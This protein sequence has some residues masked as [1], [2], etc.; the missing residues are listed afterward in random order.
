MSEIV[1]HKLAS[2]ILPLELSQLAPEWFAVFTTTRHEKRVVEHLTMKEVETFLPLYRSVRKWNNGCKVP[3]NLPLFPNYVFVRISKWERVR[4]LETPGVISFVGIGNKAAALAESEMLALQQGIQTLNC[5]P[6]PYLNVGE[7]VRIKNGPFSGFEGFLLRKKSALRVVIS[8]QL[9]MKS[10]S[11]ETDAFDI[12]PIST[13]SHLH[14]K[15]P[16]SVPPFRA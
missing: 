11:I 6:H 5:E 8:I 7:R 9:I 16:I 2:A 12:E 3:V 10:I 13:A 1:D 4:V 14:L 15:S